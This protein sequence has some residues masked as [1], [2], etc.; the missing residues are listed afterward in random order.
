M[1]Y[2]TCLFIFIYFYCSTASKST[3]YSKGY[4]EASQDIAAQ[5]SKFGFD[6]TYK[7][8]SS[9]SDEN[10]TLEDFKQLE[11]Y[12]IVYIFS[13]GGSSKS[14]DFIDTY[15]KMTPD[16]YKKYS[17]KGIAPVTQ[18]A[19]E[20]GLKS[21][22]G[23]ST[24]DSAL[25]YSN[26]IERFT[27]NM[28]S[29]LVYINGCD[30]LNQ[31]G[32]AKA[33]L[34]AKGAG[35]YLGNTKQEAAF[36]TKGISKRIFEQLLQGK[37]VN[38]PLKEAQEPIFIRSQ[39]HYVSS[40]SLALRGNPNLKIVEN[41]ISP[42]NT[43]MDAEE[44][45]ELQA[46]FPNPTGSNSTQRN[47]LQ[48]S[49]DKGTFSPDVQ[50]DCSAGTQCSGTVK[51]TAPKDEG[52]Y[53]IRYNHVAD[54]EITAEASIKVGASNKIGSCTIYT[55]PKDPNPNQEYVIKMEIPI[56]DETSAFEV[57][58]VINSEVVAPSGE[59]FFDSE[60]FYAR[61]TSF[62]QDLPIIDN[63]AT[64]SIDKKSFLEVKGLSVISQEIIIKS[65]AECG[66]RFHKIF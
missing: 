52:E 27:N 9:K 59:I 43:T 31:G 55:V 45:V 22:I 1:V 2:F 61:N 12:G 7:R 35:A 5:L 4:S 58:G 51:Y 46:T 60:R 32:L 19:F 49:A 37:V 18:S 38:S 28:P 53:K 16:E 42:A 21:I 8:N 20:K 30:S 48:W 23:L 66:N 10:I 11:Q 62:E 33:F 56:S 36:D 3:E 26:F 54:S 39:G 64:L 25:V 34:L 24:K 44:T 13:H 29:S 57:W 40:T 14:N 63:I 50:Y 6:V 17:F 41:E 47:L 65:P 15:Y